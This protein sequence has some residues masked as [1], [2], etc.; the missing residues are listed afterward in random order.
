MS[1]SGVTGTNSSSNTGTSTTTS[2]SSVLGQDAFLKLLITQLQ[3]QDPLSPMDN[4]DFIAQMAQF[5]AL[6]QMSQVREEIEG[7]RQ[8]VTAINLLGKTVKVKLEDDTELE[9]TVEAVKNL[10]STPTLTVSGKEVE[11]SDITEVVG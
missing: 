10:G 11:L 9:G 4:T 2:S 7:M 1:V 8:E 6:E 3:N 5:S